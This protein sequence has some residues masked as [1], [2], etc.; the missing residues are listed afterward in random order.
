[1]ICS[2]YYYVFGHGM[3]SKS[4]DR[5]KLR[6]SVISFISQMHILKDLQNTFLKICSVILSRF[7]VN[8]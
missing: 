3:E 1:M 5:I 7:C 4:L 6:D 2:D 8:Y